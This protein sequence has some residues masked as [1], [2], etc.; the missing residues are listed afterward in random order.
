LPDEVKPMRH[1]KLHPKEQNI[2]FECEKS[3]YFQT[4][5]D[6]IVCPLCN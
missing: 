2:C 3:P 6:A 4:V 5:H 1:T